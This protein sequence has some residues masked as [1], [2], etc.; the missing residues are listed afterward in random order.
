MKQESVLDLANLI[1]DK[2][3]V[4]ADATNEA[5]MKDALASIE[6]AAARMNAIF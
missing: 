1:R 2:A 4:I 3:G 6:A 5:D